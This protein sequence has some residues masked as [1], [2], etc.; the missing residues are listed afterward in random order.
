MAVHDGHRERLRRMFLEH[1]LESFS[2]LNAL[3]L[4]LF[5]AIPRKDTN[6]IA[7]ALLDRFGSLE[8]IF[9]ATQRELCAVDGVGES[10]ASLL[11]L[12]PQIMRKSLVS[13]AAKTKVIRSSGDAGAYLLP[14][15]LYEKDEVLLMLCLDTQKRVISC[16]EMSRGVVNAVNVNIRKM[17]E[18]ALRDKATSVIIAHNHPDGLALPSTEDDAV[19][20]Q[21]SSALR[22]VD[23]QLADHLV[24]AKD[25][26]VSYR[27]SG[28]LDLFRW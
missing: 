27:D 15:F 25:D 6:V 10:A 13:A 1:G 24:V 28:M 23:I 20:R 8:K 21:L 16:T 12:I 3:E 9:S 17:V 5:Y 4:L 7:H 22:L 18:T 19:T 14:R 26:F 11:L 2:E